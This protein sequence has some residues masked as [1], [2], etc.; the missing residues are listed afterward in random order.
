MSDNLIIHATLNRKA[1]YYAPEK[2]AVRKVIEIGAREFRELRCNLGKPNYIIKQNA[3]MMG[4]YNG[5]FNCILFLNSDGK[6]GILVNSEGADYARYSQYIPNARDIIAVHEQTLIFGELKNRMDSCIDGWLEHFK[7][8]NKFD[9]PLTDLVDEVDFGEMFVDYVS[10]RLSRDSTI[11]NCEMTSN[12]L[13]ITKR[14]LVETRLYCP[15]KF[16]M[17]VDDD[18][19]MYPIDVDS[20]NYID[21]DDEINEA[22]RKDVKCD[23]NAVERGLAAY[24]HDDHLDQKVHSIM[25]GVETRGGDIYG[26]ITVRSHGELDRSELK[27]LTND[28][29]GQ[30]SDGWGEGFEQREIKIGGDNVYISFWSSGRDY[31]LKPE[32]EVFPDREIDLNMGGI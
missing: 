13:E 28:I 18:D 25:P 9:I 19:G 24:L 30:L 14:E 2:C 20:A 21:Y 31:Y 1:E 5:A 3:D 27:K 15:L 6:D 16:Q 22:I 26:V 17:D 23:E 29:T 7:N 4:Y 8:E 11:E 12:F 32:S 10:E